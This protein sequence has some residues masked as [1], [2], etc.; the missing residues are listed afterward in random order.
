MPSTDAP[1]NASLPEKPSSPG[2]T[3]KENNKTN[4]ASSI[5]AAVNA[6]PISEPSKLSGAELKAQKKAEKAAK[7]QQVIENRQGGAGQAPATS[8]G[9]P[10][11]ILSPQGNKSSPRT[12]K[13]SGKGQHKRATS[14]VSD[15]KNL[16]I[17]SS[18][19]QHNGPVE[20]A[21]EDKTVELFRHLYKTRAKTIAGAK[22]VHPAVLSL[23]QQM[24]NYVICGS[25]ARLVATLQAFKRVRL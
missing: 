25:N 12:G 6:L 22:D 9:A 10:V 11:A 19:Q 1:A 20:P 7:R 2:A 24:S 23:G 15:L 3:D 8:V 13:E 18:Q 5:P 17:R 14:A 21:A 4:G 16:P